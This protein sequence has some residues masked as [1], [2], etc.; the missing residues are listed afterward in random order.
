MVM[1]FLPLITA[2]VYPTL[3]LTFSG[4]EPA[5]AF[6]VEIFINLCLVA[7]DIGCRQYFFPAAV[8]ALCTNVCAPPSRKAPPNGTDL[9][10]FFF[11]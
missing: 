10:A 3:A 4:R 8:G 9:V 5:Q 2:R 1:I 7:F 6:N 11:M